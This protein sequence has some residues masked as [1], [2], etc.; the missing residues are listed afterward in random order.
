MSIVFCLVRRPLPHVSEAGKCIVGA[1]DS[2]PF[3]I[4]LF[5]NTL[6]SHLSQSLSI[7]FHTLVAHPYTHITFYKTHFIPN[8][9]GQGCEAPQPRCRNEA[10][11]TR[12]T[13]GWDCS[14]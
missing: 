5:L 4:L 7:S 9:M 2:N 1:A 10:S 11:E 13:Y 6:S 14:H 12:S 8:P 3:A